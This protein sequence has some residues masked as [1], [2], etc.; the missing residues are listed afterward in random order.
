[1]NY[2]CVVMTRITIKP[3]CIEPAE[4]E[5]LQ[6]LYRGYYIKFRDSD[7]SLMT[8]E[9]FGNEPTTRSGYKKHT[10]Q[11]RDIRLD[12]LIDVLKEV[13]TAQ[14]NGTDMPVLGD[15]TGKA[16]VLWVDTGRK[17]IRMFL[18]DLEI[19]RTLAKIGGRSE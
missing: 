9:R 10:E 16:E 15:G 7:Y 12:N 19:T 1:M 4:A 2:D 8:R 3:E 6:P 14:E 11:S 18:E 13:A 5:R 17:A